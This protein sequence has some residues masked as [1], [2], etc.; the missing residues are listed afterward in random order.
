MKHDLEFEI[1]RV[2]F[3]MQRLRL[4][5]TRASILSNDAVMQKLGEFELPF[6]YYEDCMNEIINKINEIMEAK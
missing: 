3:V 1:R 6:A 5:S 2:R 4:L